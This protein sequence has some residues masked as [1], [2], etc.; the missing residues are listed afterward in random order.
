MNIMGSL[1]LRTVAIFL[2][3]FLFPAA[4]QVATVIYQGKQVVAHQIILRLRSNDSQAIARI[5]ARLPDAQVT[6]LSNSLGLNVV[7]SSSSSISNLISTFGPDNDITYVEPNFVIKGTA[8]VNDP[9]FSQLWGIQQISAPLA[10]NI[11][12]GSNAVAAV[13]DSGVDYNHPDLAANMWSAPVN[14]S[15]K[16][17]GQVFNCAAGS[18]GFNIL[19]MSC[20]PMDDNSHGTH[21]AGT[22]AAVGNNGIGVVGVNQFAK[23]VGIKF[24][25]S[26]GSGTLSG[27]I[28]AIEFAIQLKAAFASTSTPV[29]LRVLSAS[30]GGGSFT[31]SLFD[32][33]GKAGVN[34]MLFVAAAGNASSN[35][36]TNPFYPANYLAPNIIAVAATD[37]SD[38]LA[39]FS[40]YGVQS[41]SI[42]APGVGILSTVAGGGYAN[43]S[44]TSMATP[45]V[46]GAALLTLGAC[47]ALS[48][49]DL[50]VLLLG[51]ADIVGSLSG[52]VKTGRL[53]V[54]TAIQRCSNTVPVP[55]ACSV[56]VATDHWKGEYFSNLTLSGT[57][58]AVEDDGTG[59]LNFNWGNEGSPNPGCGVPG[60][61]FSARWTRTVSLAAGT[62]RFT[63]GSDDGLRLYVDGKL[64]VDRWFDQSLAPTATDVVVGSS[65]S[66]TIVVEYYQGTGTDSISVDWQVAP[67]SGVTCIATVAADHWKGEYFNGSLSTSPVMV[68]DDG[69]STLSFN[70]GNQG[71]PSSSCNVA[72]TNFSARWTRSITFTAGVW[73]FTS[74]S[75]DGMR[76]SIDGQKILDRWYDQN[77]TTQTTDYTLTAGAHT[78]VVEYYQ[79]A[80]GDSASLSWQA[81]TNSGP[82]S[83]GSVS[84]SNVTSGTSPVLIVTGTGFDSTF[85]AF[86]ISG[87]QTVEI[88]NK[89]FISSTSVT[90]TPTVTGGGDSNAI[91]QITVAALSANVALPILPAPTASCSAAAAS[92]N[93]KGEYFGNMYLSGTPLMV[94]DDGSGAISFDWSYETSPSAACNVPGR[95]YSVRWTRSA[96]FAAGTYRFTT[97]SDDGMRLY[98]D[99]QRVID[100][101]FDQS[102]RLSTT[103]YAVAAGTHTITVEYY[104]NTG[105]SSAAVSWQL[106]SNPLQIS[107]VSPSSVTTGTTPVLTVTGQG[108]DSTVRAFLITGG[109]ISEITNKTFVSATSVKVTPTIGSTADANAQLQITVGAQSASVALPILVPAGAA[110]ITSVA[111][112]R[113]RGDY[114]NNMTLSGSPLM[115]RDDG[116]SGLNFNWGNEGSPSVACNMPGHQ[117]SVRWTRSVNFASTGVYRF[118]LSSDDG[119]RLL[120]DGQKVFDV[121]FDQTASARTADL[122]ITSGTHTVVVE[123][124]QNASA[125]QAAVSWSLLSLQPSCTA[126]VTA[127]HWKGE[128]F[129]NTTLAGSPVMTRD[130]GTSNLNFT[131]GFETSPSTACSMPS[132]QWSARWTRTANFVLGV[133]RF[134]SSSDDGMRLYI[135]GQLALDTWFDHG[136]AD[137]TVDKSLTTGTHTITVEYY[138]NIGNASAGVSWVQ[139]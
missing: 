114:F 30:W 120:I 107:L 68:R 54:A 132:K 91:L 122:L 72:G 9:D 39:G 55:L 88:T 79:N 22:I 105:G 73:R 63:T 136:P 102:A 92:G 83:I 118:A 99:S 25:D 20:D 85:R 130:D 8:I 23:V 110:C 40:N 74:S 64:A 137:L 50:K 15:V 108:F 26:S 111:A 13:I 65:G 49:A 4:A 112:D 94:R 97:S 19:S 42:A 28:T 21:V 59:A 125:S 117:Y 116:T 104:Q 96:T 37:Q 78:V 17:N 86:L 66:H 75:D 12:K 10:W 133:Y 32:E 131:W 124:Y 103:D 82:L 127:D 47:P 60:R 87:S 51:S 36:D 90:V 27:A 115:T 109:Q 18:H 106:L 100:R 89:R 38:S 93:W 84:P 34:E 7:T 43:Y 35:N 41:V 98:I 81:V 44:G 70:W 134:T 31:Q 69:A 45:H 71:S 101:W 80:G 3:A 139:L 1:Y 16:L 119:M 52:K 135:D 62:Y 2:T 57:S 113:W 67:P 14:Y 6:P 129:S 53:N 33:I 126:S 123:Y 46:S 138:Q 95:Q 121:W 29:D 56:A 24:L 5:A 11:T 76:L 61:A 58:V 128:Y 77:A 48:T